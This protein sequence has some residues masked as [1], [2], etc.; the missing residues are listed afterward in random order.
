MQANHALHA[1]KPLLP[2]V[3]TGQPHGLIGGKSSDFL[4]Y[5]QKKRGFFCTNYV[6][7]TTKQGDEPTSQSLNE[8]I[9]TSRKRSDLPIHL[10]LEKEWCQL[11]DRDIHR[12]SDLVDVRFPLLP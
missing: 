10:Q 3:K 12:Q 7:A 11:A 9:H 4:V 2:A 8:L 1:Y 6:K 5:P